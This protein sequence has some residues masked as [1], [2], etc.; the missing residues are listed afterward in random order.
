MINSIIVLIITAFTVFSF[1]WLFLLF[2]PGHLFVSLLC[3]CKYMRVHV[4][5]VLAWIGMNDCISID[6]KLFVWIYSHQYDTWKW[7][8]D[9]GWAKSTNL[10]L[11]YSLTFCF[12]VTTVCIDD[13]GLHKSHFKIVQHCR[14]VQVAEGCEVILPNQDVR[15]AKRRQ[16]WFGRVHGVVAHL[17]RQ[18][19]R[20]LFVSPI[21]NL[22]Q[23]HV[24]FLLVTF[25]LQ[26]H[27]QEATPEH[28]RPNESLSWSR[29]IST[30]VLHLVSILCC[31][32]GADSNS[33]K[34]I[35]MLL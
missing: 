20:L 4:T 32:K 2:I 12:Y 25:Y 23:L 28:C 3:H 1:I 31:T 6:R 30:H 34:F 24:S 33:G 8:N 22:L 5:H 17:Y 15:V 27:F 11:G 16:F 19:S 18:K 7:G 21:I 13:S 9:T 10:H 14:F 26:C 29:L 35:S